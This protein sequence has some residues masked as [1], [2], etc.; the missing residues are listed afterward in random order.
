MNTVFYRKEGRRYK[1]VAEYDDQLMS[2][3]GEGTYITVIKPGSKSYSYVAK[4]ADADL[5]A[6][7]RKHHNELCNVLMKADEAK[8]TK[9][10]TPSE[11]AAFEAWKKMT[12]ADT[13]TLSRASASTVIT[14][15]EQAIVAELKKG[16]S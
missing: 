2:S 3:F 5:L 11:L 13:L 14:A 16:K 9:P 15:L 6:L 12:G 7:V 10:L 8:P 4:P 1:P